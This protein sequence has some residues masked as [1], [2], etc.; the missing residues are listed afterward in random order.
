MKR[1]E[2]LLIFVVVSLLVIFWI[3]SL[4]KTCKEKCENVVYSSF[5]VNTWDDRSSSKAY[6]ASKME[7]LAACSTSRRLF[8]KKVIKNIF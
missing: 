7:C 6:A 3:F 2:T 8:V 1:Y 5:D 4:D